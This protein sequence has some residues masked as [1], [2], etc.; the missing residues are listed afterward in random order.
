MICRSFRW[1]GFSV[2]AIKRK[3]DAFVTIVVIRNVFSQ[4]R[5]HTVGRAVE[6]EMPWR[7]SRRGGHAEDEPEATS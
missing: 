4:A 2:S 1:W 6:I 3:R 7:W 5:W